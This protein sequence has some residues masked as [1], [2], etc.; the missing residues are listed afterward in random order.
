MV[1]R[2]F[3]TMEMEKCWIWVYQVIC[4]YGKGMFPQIV[5]CV[6]CV[7]SV[8]QRRGIFPSRRHDDDDDD[9]ATSR[10]RHDKRKPLLTDNA[11]APHRTAPTA[12]SALPGQRTAGQR[13]WTGD[14]G[15]LG[16]DKG[17][18]FDVY[19]KMSYKT[20]CGVCLCGLGWLMAGLLSGKR[21]S[22]ELAG[23]NFG[24]RASGRC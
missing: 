23:E 10:R 14:E 22:L 18:G 24:R 1:I 9:G 11:V 4:I 6:F 7:F 17:D 2:G 8:A 19:L 15:G 13:R 3:K 21:G 20:N 5:F 12:C 16:L